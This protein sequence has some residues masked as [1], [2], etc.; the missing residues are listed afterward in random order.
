MC[1]SLTAFNILINIS[2]FFTIVL[3][4]YL[5]GETMAVYDIVAM[6]FCFGGVILVALADP[7]EGQ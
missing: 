1:I 4:Y 7:G 2:P 5:L 3:C 6:G